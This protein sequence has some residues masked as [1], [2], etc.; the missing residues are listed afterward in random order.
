[1][2]LR[3]RSL[4]RSLCQVTKLKPKLQLSVFEPTR[5]KLKLK[6]KLWPQM[7]RLHEAEDEAEAA[8]YPFLVNIVNH[9]T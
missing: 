8:S 2:R 1:M 6:P 7:L 5:L 9:H 3:S 4:S